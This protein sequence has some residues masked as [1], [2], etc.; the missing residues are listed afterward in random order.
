M[1]LIIF[2]AMPNNKV[3]IISETEV[4]PSTIVPRI[5]ES[6]TLVGPPRYE[7]VVRNV[8][9]LIDADQVNLIVK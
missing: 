5:G 2:R 4:G 3:R 6:A 9:H 1:K 7:F 8:E